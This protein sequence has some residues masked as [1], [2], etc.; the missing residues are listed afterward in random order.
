MPANITDHP[1]RPVL[2]ARANNVDQLVAQWKQRVKAERPFAACDETIRREDRRLVHVDGEV[3]AVGVGAADV[4]DDVDALL[5]WT[6]PWEGLELRIWIGIWDGMGVSVS[7]SEERG[8]ADNGGVYASV[9]CEEV[10]LD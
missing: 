6:W 3:Q 2:N 9:S 1:I 8:E 10:G 4:E 5:V 7:V